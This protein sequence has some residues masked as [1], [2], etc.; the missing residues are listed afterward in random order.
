MIARTLR[1][2]VLFLTCVIATVAQTVAQQVDTLSVLLPDIEIEAARGS[3]TL[4]TAPFAVSILERTSADISMESGLSLSGTLATLSGVRFMDRGHYALGERV[5]VR[6]MG[7]RSAFGVRG[8]YVLLDGVPLTLPDGQAILDVVDPAFIRRAEAIRGPSSTFWGNGSGGV[9]VLS[10]DAFQDS[11]V[12]RVRVLGASYGVRQ[13]SGEAATTIGKH[14]LHGF[15]STVNST[16]YRDHSRG[17]FNRA[18]VNASLD[19]GTRTRLRVSA[20]G[21]L[22][23]VESPGSLTRAEYD[24]DPRQAD[25]RNLGANAGKES[26]QLQVGAVLDHQTPIGELTVTSFGLTRRLENPLSFAYIELDRL[27]GGGRVQLQSNRGR[28][29]W[30]VG[31]D[32]GLQSDNRRNVNNNSGAP[33]TDVSLDQREDVR[34]ASSFG[35]ANIQLTRRFSAA[36]GVR[37][38]NVRFVLDDNLLANGDESGRR[39]FSAVSPSLGISYEVTSD[40]ASALVY[41]NLST[42]FE[43]PTT[44]ELVNQP[45]G[46]AGLNAGI[47][48][49][50]TR[51]FEAGVRGSIGYFE[52][53]V[54]VFQLNVS[55]RLSPFQNESGR[56]YYLNAGE[57]THRGFEISTSVWIKALAAT[58]RT[59]YTANLFEFGDSDLRGS[60]I[61]GIPDHHAYIN[62]RLN[63]LGTWIDVSA[64]IASDSFADNE[65]GERND[66]YFVTSLLIGHPSLSLGGAT[67]QSFAG[68][69][70]LF[71]ARYSAS[72]VVNAFGGRYYEPSPGRS[73]QFGIGVL[74]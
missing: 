20:A 72:L 47:S 70:N 36:G 15:A 21:A 10:S 53:D 7:W 65:N 25:I 71:N 57:N 51:G 42:A 34:N 32:V 54:A 12:A 29:G 13:V 33:G 43:T 48:A 35:Y 62:L 26:L 17:G 38:D 28:V 46:N 68:V 18:G 61:P 27:A 74:L 45:G 4:A 49:Q 5:L 19:L 39:T 11:S 23:D 14:R 31:F 24:V 44:T 41:T 59:N 37:A 52:F 3:L 1:I 60:R 66:Q 30:G 58:L 67:I 16:G 8:V 2:V 9:L 22:Q 73:Y 69:R 64:E 40:R 56:T 63:P 6:G 50:K 55:D